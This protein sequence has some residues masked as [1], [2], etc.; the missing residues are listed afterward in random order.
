MTAKEKIGQRITLGFTGTVISDC[1]KRMVKEYKAGN[2][3]LFRDNLVNAGQARQLCADIQELVK[4]ETGLPA[5]I[6]IDQEGGAVVRLPADMVNVPGAMALAASGSIKN[7][8]LAAKITADEL[9]RIGVNL[10]LA[11]VL[12]INCNMDNPAIGNRSF[13]ANADDAAAF[14]IAAIRAY[15]EA[16]LMCSGKH[17]PGHGDTAV[18]S[19]L[20]LPLVDKSLNE[21]ERRELFPFRKAI[22]AGIPAIM[23]THILFPQIENE[24]LPATMSKKILKGLLRDSMG[25]R[26]LI[27]SDGMEMKAIK[28][29]YGVPNGCVLALD[30]GVD[31]VFLCH[32]SD[33]ME[34]S[35]KEIY[36]AFDNGRF[37]MEE[38]DASVGRI[39]SYKE[40]YTDFGLNAKEDIDEVVAKRKEQNAALAQSTITPR[41]TGNAMPPLGDCPLF[42]GSLA[43]RSTIASAKPDSSLSFSRWF[44]EHFEAASSKPDCKPQFLETPVNPSA[45]E[46]NDIID[47]LPDSSSIVFGSYNGHLNKGQ[48][49][50]AKSL[51]ECAKKRTSQD[52][53]IPFI[54]MALRNPW[55]LLELPEGAQGLALFEYTEKSFTAAAKVLKNECQAKGRMPKWL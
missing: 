25:F 44:A 36:S 26:G 8:A 49:D 45:M 19:H 37:N 10:N 43:Y 7:A 24:K 35:M 34:N 22:E 23:T 33:D 28:D 38:F 31:I 16:G 50:L 46:I 52:S 13:A 12:D 18:D 20:D 47:K 29:Y 27:L 42:M 21:L 15:A 48:M 53:I 55:D 39:I 41:Y 2:V 6:S 17:F 1:L 40:K 11:P 5:F 4:G 9:R 32:E 51:F 14:A 54:C 30:A 3:I